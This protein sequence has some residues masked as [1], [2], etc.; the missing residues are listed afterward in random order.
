MPRRKFKY[1]LGKSPYKGVLAEIARRE[2]VTRQAIS[3]AIKIGNV[4]IA[5]IVEK[6]C[7]KRERVMEKLYVGS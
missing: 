3:H 7:Q 5:T 6:A 2:G 4:R 1:D